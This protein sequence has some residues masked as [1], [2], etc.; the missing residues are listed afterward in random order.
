M[1]LSSLPTVA[2]FS[3]LRPRSSIDCDVVDASPTRHANSIKT[4]ASFRSETHLENKITT[5]PTDEELALVPSAPWHICGVQEFSW[6]LWKNLKIFVIGA[7]FQRVC[8]EL[9]G[10]SWCLS[11]NRSLTFLSS[12]VA[13]WD[14]RLEIAG[15]CF[16]L[17]RIVGMWWF[18]SNLYAQECLQSS[19]SL[20][21][22]RCPPDVYICPCIA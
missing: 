6:E 22:R 19:C 10:M 21:T 15:I 5:S 13:V 14:V 9:L 17:L 1:F 3:Q 12:F 11:V 2:L 20:K 16:G 7:H 8:F 4:S 18:A